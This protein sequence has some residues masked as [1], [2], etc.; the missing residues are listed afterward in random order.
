MIQVSAG[1]NQNTTKKCHKVHRTHPIISRKIIAFKELTNLEKKKKS[2]REAA[3]LLEI[4]NSTMQSWSLRKPTSKTRPELINFFSTF[5]GTDFLQRNIMAVMKLMKCGPGGIRGMQEYLRNSGLDCFVASSEGALQ[6]FWVRCETHILNFGENEE[7]K[8]SSTM[9]QRK[10]TLGLDEMFRSNRPCLVAIDVVSNYIL[11]EKFT[12]DRTAETWFKELTPRLNEVNI[13]I[14]QVVSDLCGAIRS[15]TKKLEAVHIPELFHA[16][17]EISKATSVALASQEKNA[18]KALT[19]AEET[20]KKI[21]SKPQE[22][23]VKKHKKRLQE[24]RKLRYSQDIYKIELEKK[25]KNREAVKSAVREMGKI[26]HP[27]NL[28]NGKIQTAVEIKSRFDAQFK[29]IK[30]RIEE[31]ELSKP[32]ID[33][34]EKA[35]RAFDA[36]V[37]YVKHFF[38]IYASFLDGLGLDP[39]QTIFFN[40]II[41][42]ICYLKM[43]WRR[44]TTKAKEEHSELLKSLE[45]KIREA[46]WPEELKKKWMTQGQELAETFQRSSSC[47]EGRNGML[48][49]NHHRFHRLNARTLKALTIIHNFDVKRSNG[50]TAAERFFENKHANLFEYLIEKVRIPSRPQQQRHDIHKRLLGR[51]KRL[52][53]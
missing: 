11:L 18:E 25:K 31:V 14:G 29:T 45:E 13:E 22:F 51:K 17:H 12:D 52:V 1:A 53:A 33:R 7:K 30:E 10:I 21:Q 23:E 16:Q 20:L 49:M 26:H 43:T 38:L 37:F 8:L 15:C 48:S 9:R 4:P 36:I 46:P 32:C 41:F 6:K 3:D 47:V 5:P 34:I 24:I 40:E 42:P 50:T 27:I 44:L 39:E 19:E 35:K 2:A 28:K